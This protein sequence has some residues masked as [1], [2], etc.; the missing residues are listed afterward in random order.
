MKKKLIWMALMTKRLYKKFTFL[1]ILLLIP[2]LTLVYGLAAQEDS[3]MVTIAL[4]TEEQSKLADQIIQ[5]LQEDDKIIR[6]ILCDTPEEAEQKVR[7]GKADAAWIFEADLAER[8]AEFVE[9]RSKKDAFVQVLERETEIS[10]ILAR[11]KLGAA[12]FS[13]TSRQMYLDHI[14]QNAP[15]LDAVSEEKLLEHYDSIL[16]GNDLFEYADVESVVAESMEQANYLTAPIR[17]L[18]AVVVVLCGLATAMYYIQDSKNGT[19]AWVPEE[20][21]SWVELGY[22]LISVVNVLTVVVVSLAVIGQ[23]GE[24]GRELLMAILYALAVAVFSMVV[25]RICG[26]LSVLGTMLPLLL[27]TMMVICPV[28][29]DFGFFRKLSY[30]FPPTYYIQAAVNNAYLLYF[31]G[32]IVLMALL[33]WLLGIVLRRK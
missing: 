28:F 10:V 1:L 21:R 4:A 3:G 7:L 14:R 33:Y 15:E 32:Y 24:L 23:L 20:K 5:K 31:P 9:S 8:I 2:A 16:M 27:V 29:F 25:R 19:F 17:G 6:Y 22:S 30:L 11:E 18:L 13:H 26:G 12:I